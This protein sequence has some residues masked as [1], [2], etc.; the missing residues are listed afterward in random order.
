MIPFSITADLDEETHASEHAVSGA[1][2]VFPAD[3]NADQFLMWDDV[4]GTLVWA[5]PAGSGDVESVGDCADGACLDGS[6]DG[7]TYVRIYDGN[8]HYLELN[9]GDITANRAVAFEVFRKAQPFQEHNA[10]ITRNPTMCV[11]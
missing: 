5:S 7:G 2:T 9:P 4:P 11:L 6:A 1:D 10:P 3:P 8:S